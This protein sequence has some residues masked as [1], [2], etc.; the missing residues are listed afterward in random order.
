MRAYTD[1]N[2]DIWD[3]LLK[4]A[5]FAYNNSIHSTTGFTPHELA[6]GFKIQ[7]PNHLMRQKVTYNY[8]NLA[9]L[10]RNNI[11]KALEIAKEHLH[12]KKLQNKHYYD[13]N[14]KTY[15]V[16]IGDMVLYKNPVKKHKFQNVYD[17]PYQV[18]DT[19]DSYIEILRDNRKMKVHKNMIKKS[20]IQEEEEQEDQTQVQT[21]D[22]LDPQANFLIK[23]VYGIDFN[24]H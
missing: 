4:F 5:T 15:D 12:N 8:E 16:K 3:Q 18:I 22:N 6:H 24:V 20:N 11:A 1:K 10:T 21:L 2:K 14:A 17:G 23:L 7:I 13:S 19:F 9:D